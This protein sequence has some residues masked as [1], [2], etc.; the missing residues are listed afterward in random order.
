MFLAK[1]Y[2]TLKQSVLDPQGTAVQKALQQHGYDEVQDVRIG[3]F[4][5]VQ[6]ATNDKAYAEERV[7]AMCE[8]L[9]ANPVIETYR[10]ELVEV[11]A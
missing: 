1:I 11:E 6:I 3:K 7:N 8:R 9:L 4:M 10:F 5:E 2:V